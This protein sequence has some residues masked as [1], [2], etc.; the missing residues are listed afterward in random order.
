MKRVSI[1]LTVIG[2]ILIF[3]AIYYFRP[4]LNVADS[5]TMTVNPKGIKT[6]E[7]PLFIGLL[8]TFVGICFYFIAAADEKKAKR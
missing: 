7:W 8:T 6:S 5:D 4:A 3:A 1:V 2:I